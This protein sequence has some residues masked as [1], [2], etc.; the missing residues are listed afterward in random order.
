VAFA[1]VAVGMVVTSRLGPLDARWCLAAA[2]LAAGAAIVLTGRACT[3]AMATG[4]VLIG[5]AW[6]SLRVDTVPRDSLSALMAA[7]SEESFH[8]H[9]GAPAEPLV[10][11]RGTVLTPPKPSPAR[12]AMARFSRFRPRDVFVFRASF[13]LAGDTWISTRGDLWVHAEATSVGGFRPGDRLELSATIALPEAPLNPGEPDL[14]RWARAHGFAGSAT[15]V[16]AKAVPAEGPFERVQDAFTRARGNL[17]ARAHAALSASMSGMPDDEKELVTGLVLGDAPAAQEVRTAFNRVG[18]AHILSISGFHLVVM[19]G[20]ALF[21]VR[22]TGDRG[23]LEPLI[24]AVLVGAYLLVVPPEAPVVRSGILVLAL[25]AS[26]ALG[27]RYDRLTV[28]AWVAT[29]LVLWQPLDLFA[30]GFQLSCGLTALLLWQGRSFTDRLLGTPL[31]TGMEPI[32][33]SLGTRVA[34]HMRALVGTSV[35]CWAASVPLVMLHVGSASPLAVPATIISLP[36]LT[37]VLWLAYLALFAGMA[38][39]AFGDA[40]TP[41]ASLLHATS[42]WSLQVVRWFDSLDFAS[43]RTPPVS[44]AWTLAATASLL[45]LV[46]SYRRSPRTRWRWAGRLAPLVCIAWLLASALYARSGWRASDD[47]FVR[48]DT[49]AVGDGSCHL[50]RSGT[51]QGEDAVL[52]D[53]GSLRPGIGERVVPQALRAMGV[54][55][56]ASIIVTH[57]DMDHYS[58]VLD[59]LE[60]LSVQRVYLEARFFQ[61]A[62]TTPDGP[63]AFLLG[64]LR[65]REVHVLRLARGD[66]LV[67]GEARLTVIGPPPEVDWPADNDHSLT[68]LVTPS[69]LPLPLGSAAVAPSAPLDPT[70]TARERAARS[71]VGSPALLLTGDA[72]PAALERLTPVVSS[73][74]HVRVLELPHHGSYNASARELVETINPEVVVQSTGP[75]RVGDARWASTRVGRGWLVT[76]SAGAVWVELSPAGN[77]TWGRWFH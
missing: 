63:A 47:S 5:A 17:R 41:F 55:R 6:F 33:P 11:L 57:P 44:S 18:L 14:R 43:V 19:A 66:S 29:A 21:V 67:F 24:V 3:M 12:G 26:E 25:L 13:A 60:P 42:S 53:C 65:A 39:G 1:C 46:W 71:G 56:V 74:A 52:W 61:Q 36:L 59:V 32:E 8:E 28:L 75:T 30:P 9:V 69:T 64:E 2:A 54:W 48:M 49:I 27:R 76:E 51:G 62:E 68:A 22:L 7:A 58:G 16:G 70:E 73:L 35:L 72:G 4:A 50:L 37:L 20:L 10:T 45:A 23:V 40:A 34:G 77:A 31:L 15:F 38:T